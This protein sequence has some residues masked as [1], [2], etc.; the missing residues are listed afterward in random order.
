[1]KAL[2]SVLA[3][4]ALALVLVP[5]F[6]Q[7]AKTP[8]KAA[9]A[10]TVWFTNLDKA[11]AAAKKDHKVLMVDFNATWCGPCQMYKRDVFSKAPFQNA[12]KDMIL[13]DIDCDQQPDLARKY[14]V[15]G[16]PDLRFFSPAGKP[17]GKIVGFV[18][19]QKLLDDIKKAKAPN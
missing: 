3:I 15:Q 2:T 9:A 12:T 7:Q 19:E 18:G 8:S 6:A 14:G 10:K 11:L 17:V 13:V 1:M 16:I 5:S 4:T